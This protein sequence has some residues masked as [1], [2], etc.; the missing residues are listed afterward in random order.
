MRARARP[1]VPDGQSVLHLRS[2]VRGVRSELRKDMTREHRTRSA[3]E[4]R[5][6][7]VHVGYGAAVG[8][9]GDFEPRE[10]KS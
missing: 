3:I 9:W 8:A 10:P 6:A 2:V 1:I 5:V 4:Q 7:A